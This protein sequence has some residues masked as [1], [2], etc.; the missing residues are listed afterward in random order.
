MTPEES[1]LM[2]GHADTCRRHAILEGVVGAALLVVALLSA[3]RG[4]TWHATGAGI[5]AG[6][7]LAAAVF[8]YIRGRQ[9]MR[10]A[11]RRAQPEAAPWPSPLA[12]KGEA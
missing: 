12:S 2:H 5:A 8:T 1:N 11:S 7:T 9:W 6:A 10:V 3:A 4:E